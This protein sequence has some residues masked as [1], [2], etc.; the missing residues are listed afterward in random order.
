MRTY[1]LLIII[2][3]FLFSS[4]NKSK[5]IESIPNENSLLFTFDLNNSYVIEPTGD[6]IITNNGYNQISYSSSVFSTPYPTKKI[7]LTDGQI[8]DTLSSCC[9]NYNYLTTP[10][11]TIEIW[12]PNYNSNGLYFYNIDST[13]NDFEISIKNQMKFNSLGSNTHHLDSV[14]NLVSTSGNN[15][16][17]NKVSEAYLQ[18]LNINSEST[19]IEFI[20]QTIGGHT[21]KGSYYGTLSNF[22]FIGCDA[23]CD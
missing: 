11:T 1:H 10:T 16:S 23:D 5:K 20:V 6:T 12:F 15:I 4:C 9:G 7:W 13:V 14:N 3:V 17:D 19:K 2:N 21:L 8:N 22:R 18:V